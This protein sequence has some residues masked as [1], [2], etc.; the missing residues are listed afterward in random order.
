MHAG[1]AALNKPANLAASPL[2]INR[3]ALAYMEG[4]ASSC[5]NLYVRR[6]QRG[7]LQQSAQRHAALE[8]TKL[9]ARGDGDL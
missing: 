1:M 6:R 8:M 9:A 3:F 5:P 7:A 2:L 4:H